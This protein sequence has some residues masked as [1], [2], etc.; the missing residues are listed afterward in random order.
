MVVFGVLM[1]QLAENTMKTG[2]LVPEIPTVEGFAI[3]QK[4][5]TIFFFI[6]CFSES[7]FASC[8]FGRDQVTYVTTYFMTW[9]SRCE[10]KTKTKTKNNNLFPKI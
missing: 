5:K 8:Y 6:S 9:I 3:Q 4:K 10:K 2:W 7:N 1:P